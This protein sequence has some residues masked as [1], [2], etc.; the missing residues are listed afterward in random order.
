MD[1]KKQNI[2]VRLNSSDLRKIKEIAKRL[3]ARESDVMRFAIKNTLSRLGPLHETHLRGSDLIPV[4]LELG[5][6]LGN[7]FD[8]DSSV[9]AEI[10]NNGVEDLEKRVDNR[11][12]ELLAMAIVKETYLYMTMSEFGLKDVNQEQAKDLMLEYFYNKYISRETTGFEKIARKNEKVVSV[13]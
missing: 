4:F 13:V 10:I 11:D 6:E 1:N 9:L 2:S 5:K 8:L 7:H 12:I 3:H